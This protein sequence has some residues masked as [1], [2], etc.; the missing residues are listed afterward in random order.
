M[1][2]DWRRRILQQPQ[3][4]DFFHSFILSFIHQTMNDNVRCSK[5]RTVTGVYLAHCLKNNWINETRLFILDC[6]THEERQKGRIFGSINIKSLPSILFKRISN[7]CNKLFGNIILNQS[8]C[9]NFQQCY[10]SAMIV[11]LDS[12]SGIRNE[13]TNMLYEKLR[14]FSCNVNYLE[15]MYCIE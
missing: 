4:S 7:G 6:R 1:F 14:E 13:F 12:D 2:D 9:E 10:K 3:R 8:D 11:L 5:K 15:G